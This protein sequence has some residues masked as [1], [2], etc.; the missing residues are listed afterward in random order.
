[1]SD[2]KKMQ[3]IGSMEFWLRDN[4]EIEYNESIDCTFELYGTDDKWEEL[5][6]IEKYWC[7]C[8][9]FAAAMGF[10]EHTITKWFGSY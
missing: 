9:Y 6:S 4:R 3:N 7:L 5:I 10:S 1:M 2:K 8:R